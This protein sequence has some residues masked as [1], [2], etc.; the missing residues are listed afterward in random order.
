MP[1]VTQENSSS[2]DSAAAEPPK[3]AR[4]LS[5]TELQMI[6]NCVKLADELGFPRS[7][8]QIYGLVFISRRPVTAQDCVDALRISRSSAGQGL[9]ALRD[10]GAIRPA[11][12]LGA[13]R[14]AFII[15]PD[16][17][18]L[19]KSIVER[20]VIPAF[21]NFFNEIERIEQSLE[22]EDQDFLSSRIQKMERWRS[23]LSRAQKWL[24]L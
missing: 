17:G 21:D 11:F 16:L 9:K 18:V 10:A 13:R 5:E 15:E 4:T 20:K 1:K 14:E 19:V 22:S 23:K 24:L 6:E 12:E 7:L 8:S 3:E 2:S